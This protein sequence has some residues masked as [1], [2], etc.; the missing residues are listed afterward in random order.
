MERNLRIRMLLEAGDKVSRP[1]RD[2]ASGSGRAARA[3]QDTRDQLAKLNRAQADLAAFRTLKGDLR[4]TEHQLASTRA[5][6][7][8]LARQ[9]QAADTPTRKLAREFDAAKRSAAE[10]KARHESESA[11][12][13]R[14]R[15]RMQEAGLSAGGLVQHE[16]NLRQAIARTNGELEEQTR[17]LQ[18]ASDRARRLGAAR[19]RFGAMQGTAAG[20]AASGFSAIET[21]RAMGAPLL[22]AVASAQ[23]FEAGMTDI[24]QKADLTRA[25]AAK[26][27][28]GLLVAARAANQLPESLQQGVDVLSGFGLDPRKATQMIAPIGRAATAYKAEIADLAAASF[29]NLDNL[30]VPIEQTGRAIDIMAQAGKAG[31]FEMKDMAQYFPALSAGYQGLGQHGVGAVADLSAALQIARKGA[32]DAASAATNVQNVLQ[33]ISSPATV[34]AFDKMGV[35]LPKA[36]K[37]LYAE[38]KTPLEA[39]AELTNKTLKG[40]MSKLGNLFEDAQVQQGLRPLIANMKEYRRIRAEALAAGGTTD[41]DFVERMK[42]SAE[43]TKR[44]QVNASTLGITLGAKLLPAVN[45]V[46][47]QANAFTD[48]VAKW[49]AA[50]PGLTKGLLMGAAAFAALFLVLGGGAIL[51]AGLVAPFAAL[52][53]VSTALGIG[54][55]PLIG[56]VGGVVL[57]VLALG[58]AIYAI[59]AN[60]GAIGT[61]FSGLGESIK[62]A[63]GAAIQFVGRI[64]LNF[65]PLG[66]FVQGFTALLA[67]LRGPLGQRMVAAGG[68]IVRGIITGITGMLGQLRDTIVGAASSAANWFKSK[69][70]I[71][72]PS[73][74][75]AS[76]GGFMMQGLDQGIARDQDRPVERIDH[77]ANRLTAAMAAQPPGLPPAPLLQLPARRETADHAVPMAA[78]Q[79]LRSEQVR[80]LHGLVATMAAALAAGAAPAAASAKP[81]AAAAPPP[82]PAITIAAGAIVIQQQPGQSDRDLARLIRAELEQLL[83]N[84]IG[85]GRRG[86]MADRPDGDDL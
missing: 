25:Q 43:Q 70:D 71:N 9:M 86:S 44:L 42:D 63:I 83:R 16:R 69:L 35:D 58:A 33:K 68:D 8:E 36:L 76:F 82:P 11:E 10:L 41:R 60:W 65:S 26:M 55:L 66:L 51:I 1:L 30:K 77:L 38:G 73:R 48:R 17:R 39:I 12:L 2:I 52:A 47:E 3:L 5:R 53:A 4:G 28:D 31:A 49:T 7:G 18:H 45:A 40:D 34:R 59:Y 56:I 54:V 46:L 14:L 23:Q 27:G 37:K 20:M 15:T 75:F 85:T 61:W 6:V 29:A 72:S 24:A 22:G 80:R 13:Q 57:G 19:E 62:S 21:G 32:G 79:A 64:L 74:L 67:W 81:S 78:L 50:N 84:S